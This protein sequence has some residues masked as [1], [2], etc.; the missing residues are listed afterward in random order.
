MAFYRHNTV[1]ESRQRPGLGRVRPRGGF[2]FVELLVTLLFIT[3][4]VPTAMRG[5]GLCTRVAGDSQRRIEAAALAKTQLTELIVTGDWQNGA[6]S[7]NFGSDWPGYKWTADVSNWTD[8][9]NT[10]TSLRQLSVSV[11]WQSAGAEKK[12]TLT[13]LIYEEPTS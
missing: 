11:T 10:N 13:T 8:M 9:A 7:G 1:V 3:L 5:V 12:F 4:I 2:T 6:R